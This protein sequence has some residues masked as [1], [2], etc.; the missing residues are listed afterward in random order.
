MITACN[1]SWV[2]C[3]SQF[4]TVRSVGMR[5]S[6]HRRAT[7]GSGANVPQVLQPPRPDEEEGDDQQDQPAA[8]VIAAGA[9]GAEGAAEA[10][11]EVQESEDPAHE[12]QAAVGGEVLA[13]ELKTGSH[14]P[15]LVFLVSR[16]GADPGGW[17][18]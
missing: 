13:D 3:L 5:A 9:V 6:P 10:A 2:N 12:L 7:S 1:A 16:A 4:T 14:D 17:S 18:L 8:P 15:V 11:V